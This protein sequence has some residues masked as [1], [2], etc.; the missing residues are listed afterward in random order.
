MY[1]NPRLEIQQKRKESDLHWLLQKAGELHGHFCPFVALGVKAAVI[2][3][4][5]LDTDTE[6]ID[7]EIIAIVE[8][9]NCF[10][11]GVQMVSGC[12]LGNNSLIYKDYGKNAVTLAKRNGNAVRISILPGYPGK[13]SQAVPGAAEMFER[14]IQ[15]RETGTFEEMEHF[16]EVWEALSFKQLDVHEEDQFHIERVATDLPPRAPILP[17]VICSRCGEAVMDSRARLLD[18][19]VVCLPCS[20]DGYFILEGRGMHVESRVAG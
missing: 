9:N 7:E 14:F 17:S 11:D 12:T 16:K 1:S 5:Q 6:G 18:G 15:R 4:D 10:V 19:K 8:V 3:L 2:A 13:M 20:K